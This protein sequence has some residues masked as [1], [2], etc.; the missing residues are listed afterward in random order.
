MSE[1]KELLD[2]YDNLTGKTEQVGKQAALLAWRRSKK[3]GGKETQQQIANDV[4]RSNQAISRW[5]RVGQAIDEGSDRTFQELYA[6]F[7]I[8]K[9]QVL[10]KDAPT[11]VGNKTEHQI[12]I[13]QEQSK[14]DKIV[15]PRGLNKTEQPVKQ[16][17]QDY[18]SSL[19]PLE[20]KQY[21]AKSARIDAISNKTTAVVYHSAFVS[22]LGM[23][24]QTLE[25]AIK[26]NGYLSEQERIGAHDKIN[27]ILRLMEITPKMEIPND[28]SELE[29]QT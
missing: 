19:S 22:L 6:S 16:E 4:G 7:K 20:R 13:Q 24:Q 27:E 12:V 25:T 18:L 15:K 17:E 3:G 11:Q 28:L 2:E 8:V 5:C 21:E 1:L 9:T 26:H 23:A 29:N 14:A 10:N